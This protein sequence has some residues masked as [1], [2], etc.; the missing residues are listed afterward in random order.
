MQEEEMFGNTPSDFFCI[1]G[2]MDRF[3]SCGDVS[4][5][6]AFIHK[7]QAHLILLYKVICP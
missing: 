4:L 2:K 7:G 1:L 5:W 3:P 6:L